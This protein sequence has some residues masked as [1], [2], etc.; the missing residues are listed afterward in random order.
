MIHARNTRYLSVLGTTPSP[1]G[2]LVSPSLLKPWPRW[3]NACAN[4]NAP[5]LSVT[6]PQT[7]HS[8]SHVDRSR[9]GT[10]LS[11]FCDV[12]RTHVAGLRALAHT[13]PQDCSPSP[14]T[15]RRPYVCP[16][17]W[18]HRPSVPQHWDLATGDKHIDISEEDGYVLSANGE[19]PTQ[20][21]IVP[22]EPLSAIRRA[23]PG[24]LRIN[25]PWI[26]HRRRV[27][28]ITTSSPTNQS[29]SSG[30]RI[31]DRLSNT[32]A[33][34]NT[35]F[36][37]LFNSLR[38]RDALAHSAAKEAPSHTATSPYSSPAMSRTPSSLRQQQRPVLYVQ[39]SSPVGTSAPPSTPA[40]PSPCPSAAPFRP[41]GRLP[42]RSPLPVWPAEHYPR[43]V[44]V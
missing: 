28:G 9:L 13:A 30:L 18:V 33:T 5:H 1:C 23:R 7:R 42:K 41:S 27:S 10:F 22:C 8:S 26:L 19:G 21:A 24:R 17:L 31:C 16:P 39:T 44:V 2:Q 37:N 14:N 29:P 12:W 43:A 35:D 34:P 25:K 11:F 20:G 3:G 6:R 15:T 32:P 40:L 38:Q 36:K 4:P